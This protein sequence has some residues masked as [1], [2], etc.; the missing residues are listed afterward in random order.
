MSHEDNME[1]KKVFHKPTFD[2]ISSEKKDKILSVALNEFATKGYESANINTIA[3]RSGVSVGSLYKY[4]DSKS[5]LFLTTV[6]NGMHVL[7]TVLSEISASD[8]DVMVKLEK[9][10]RTAVDHSRKQADLIRLYYEITSESNAEL[11]RIISQQLESISAQ[12]YIETIIKGQQTG[13]I[14]KDI[15]PK[16]AA[17]LL[18]NLIMGI[19][20]TYT[21]DYYIERFKT[22][23][24]ENVFDD[25][26]IA[27]ESFLKFVKAALEPKE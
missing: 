9:L 15:D 1:D 20:F 5:D 21:C 17:F 25:D 23:A 18:D 7:E 11:V 6:H 10:V 2:N 22:F 14:R 26:D 13:E 16:M 27:I 12:V 3:K 24:G 19:Q 4:F 8:D